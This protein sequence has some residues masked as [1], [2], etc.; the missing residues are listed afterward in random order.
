MRYNSVNPILAH[1]VKEFL[2]SDSGDNDINYYNF[3]LLESRKVDEDN[4]EFAYSNI[5]DDYMQE[6]KSISVQVT[7]NDLEK[8][9]YYYNP[10]LLSFDMYGT[11]ELDFIILKLNGIIDPKEFD[12]ESI[13]LVRRSDLSEFLSA[14]Y[15]AEKAYL[16]YNRENKTKE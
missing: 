7:M 11:T 6:L 2:A 15:S 13:L 12:M 5:L 14:I 16:E 9:K 3:S 4:V 10:D 8:S 1:T